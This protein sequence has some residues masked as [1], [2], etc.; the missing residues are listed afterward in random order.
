M[1]VFQKVPAGLCPYVS[2]QVGYDM[3]GFIRR[4][5]DL[6]PYAVDTGKNFTDAVCL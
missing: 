4:V 1:P 6:L 2:K 3:E 5:F